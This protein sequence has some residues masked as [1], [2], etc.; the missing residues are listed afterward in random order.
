MTENRH[1]NPD[2]PTTFEQ[3]YQRLEE[4]AR[5]LDDESTPIERSFTLFEEGQEL[6]KYCQAMLDQAEKRLKILQVGEDGF[7]IKE[8]EIDRLG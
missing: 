6:L 4:I 5:E 1:V 2:H 7:S 8:E 3:A